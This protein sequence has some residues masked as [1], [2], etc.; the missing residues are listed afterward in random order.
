LRDG[1]LSPV[2]KRECEIVSTSATQPL[3]DPRPRSVRIAPYRVPGKD[4]D[5]GNETLK[6]DSLAIGETPARGQGVGIAM[7]DELSA[8]FEQV[9]CLVH[10]AGG[11]VDIDEHAANRWANGLE[12]SAPKYKALSDVLG[13]FIGEERTN[14]ECVV[15]IQSRL[16]PDN[17]VL[18]SWLSVM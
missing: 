17:D 12:V 7:C 10:D 15:G 13:L 9:S 11:D 5:S 18:R 8:E 16:H 2:T 6:L 1:H 4:S 3:D 14:V